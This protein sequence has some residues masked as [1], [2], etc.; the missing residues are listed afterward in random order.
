V[1]LYESGQAFL[2]LVLRWNGK[3]W[4]KEVAPNPGGTTGNDYNQLVSVRCVSA[5][6]CWAVGTYSNLAGALL[7]EALHWNGK[8]WLKVTMPNP[9]GT[10]SGHFN[11]LVDVTCISSA[12]CWAV[13]EYGTSSSAGTGLNQILHWNGRKWSR[14]DAPNPAGVNATDINS[15]TSVRC[16][17][18]AKCLVVGTYGTLSSPSTFLNESLLWNGRK[19]STV[20]TPDPAGKATGANNQLIALTCASPSNCWAVG[21]SGSFSTPGPTLNTVLHWNG[22]KWAQIIVPNPGGTSSGDQSSLYG[23]YCSSATNCWAAG[24]YRK[25]SAGAVLNQTLHWNGV[26]WALVHTPNPA[27]TATGDTNLLRAVRCATKGDCW[28]VGYWEGTSGN[29]MNQALHWNGH[30]WTAP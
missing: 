6:D 30:R 22:S 28:A 16:A 15:V 17:S 18:A 21:I 24:D 13:G 1:G 29:R 23:T 4:R 27:G 25:S 14:R 3:Q 12:N 5:R 20:R 2:N 9:A 19:W 8:K 26:H 7:N 11:Q 10:L